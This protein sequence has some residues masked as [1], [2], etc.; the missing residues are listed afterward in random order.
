[1]IE[2]NN[3]K[4]YGFWDGDF[5]FHTYVYGDVRANIFRVRIDN[6]PEQRA[7]QNATNP[8]QVKPGWDE[9]LPATDA[10]TQHWLKQFKFAF[11]QRSELETTML[12]RLRL[13]GTVD[14][15]D[16]E[17]VY[18][19]VAMRSLSWYRSIHRDFVQ[20]D[21]AVADVK[22]RIFS[23]TETGLWLTGLMK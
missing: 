5:T 7:Q 22:G 12:R 16:I 2:A 8:N 3:Q 14:H 21:V 13:E 4:I 9:I 11:P 19:Q 6:T 18:A 15:R 1:M 23:L 20:Q 10:E 17:G